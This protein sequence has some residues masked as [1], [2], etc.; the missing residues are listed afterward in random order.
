MVN[1]T[2]IPLNT[3]E[4]LVNQLVVNNSDGTPSMK[5]ATISYSHARNF[6]EPCITLLGKSVVNSPYHLKKPNTLSKNSPAFC[7]NV[8]SFAVFVA[9]SAYAIPARREKIA[10]SPSA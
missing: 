7:H 3:I 1:S 2:P 10:V 4:A 5:S 9:P 6:T 8:G